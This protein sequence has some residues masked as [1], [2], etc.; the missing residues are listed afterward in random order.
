[1]NIVAKT[2]IVDGNM[3]N[4]DAKESFVTNTLRLG[5]YMYI[6]TIY[7][8]IQDITPCSSLYFTKSLNFTLAWN[9][10][11]NICISIISELKDNIKDVSTILELKEMLSS[12]T[13]FIP[14]DISN[15][16]VITVFIVWFKFK[17]LNIIVGTRENITV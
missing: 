11:E 7:V 14:L 6:M 15:I 10:N 4:F 9:A 8:I 2:Y 5:V 1:M 16:P 3:L 12:G 17:S 13:A